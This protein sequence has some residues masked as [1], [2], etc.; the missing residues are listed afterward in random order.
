[1]LLFA[2]CLLVFFVTVNAADYEQGKQAYLEKDYE[3]ALT[4]LEPLAQQGEAQAQIIM[5]LIYDR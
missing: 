4:I 1:M 3:R 5:G 2:V